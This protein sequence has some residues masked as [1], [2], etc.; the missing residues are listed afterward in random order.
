MKTEIEVMVEIQLRGGSG[1]VCGDGAECGDGV[2]DRLLT[3]GRERALGRKLGWTM[4]QDGAL[5]GD[6]TEGTV[7]AWIAGRP[8]IQ[9]MLSMET[10]VFSWY[11]VGDGFPFPVWNINRLLKLFQF[12]PSV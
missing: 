7:E 9:A 12:A 5:C 6:E 4:G 3:I 1:A 10:P 8:W 11:P 2:E